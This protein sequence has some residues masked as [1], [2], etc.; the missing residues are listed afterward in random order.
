MFSKLHQRLGT[1]GL[2]IAVVALVAALAGTAF[3]AAGLTGKQKKEVKKIAKQFAGKNGKNGA[4]G[5]A[6]PVGPAGPQGPAGAKGDNGS[7]GQ[8]GAAGAT[9]PTGATG[10]TGQGTTGA[11]GATGATG[12][13][14]SPWTAGGTLP[15]ESTETGA[16]SGVA[17]EG[18]QSR[19]AISFPIPLAAP[20]PLSNVRIVPQGTG[21][22]AHAD[23]ES[24]SE[25]IKNADFAIAVGSY[26]EGPGIP[27]ETTV[28]EELSSTEY[29]L[30]A[31]ATATATGVL[32]T[33][34]A[35]PECDN[36][37]GV[38]A[39]AENPEAD[40]GYLCVFVAR[41]PSPQTTLK[42]GAFSIA[43]GASTSGALITLEGGA[44]EPAS[45]HGTFAV[46]G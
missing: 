21:K 5:P 37:T 32:L 11:T 19:I 35:P 29:K 25:L 22:T 33:I 7:A 26:I 44:T 42:P 1:A 13:T 12:T 43:L 41:G 14:G 17:P 6:G 3:A 24:G 23:T 27:A 4:T 9:G 34:V 36:G 31:P 38:A 8:A 45:A 30:S 39:S 15:S 10:V 46:T 28:V 18:E 2:V 16:W 20:L 40:S